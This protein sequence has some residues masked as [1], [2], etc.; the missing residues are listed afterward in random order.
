MITW[1]GVP[2]LL[3]K[4]LHDVQGETVIGKVAFVGLGTMGKPMAMNIARAGF[5]LMV[6]DLRE[7]PVRELGKL[8]AQIARS[9]KE[10]AEY[11]ELVEIAVLDDA[12]VR[13]AL[14]GESGVLAA[15]KPGS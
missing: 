8:G 13:A 9:A 15:A 2:T 7:E 3:R 5:D 4:A 10:A 6:Y 1:E 11:G 12:Q 14:F